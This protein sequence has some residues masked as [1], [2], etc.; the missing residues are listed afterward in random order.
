MTTRAKSGIFKP[1]TYAAVVLS[2]YDH[3]LEP[4]S[5]KEALMTPGWLNAMK[6]EFEALERNN[7]WTLVDL[8][9]GCKPIGGKW[10]FKSKYKLRW[11]FSKA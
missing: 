3:T 5:I 6:S 1:K 10:V 11:E 2:T 9:S 4:T 7:T 8:P